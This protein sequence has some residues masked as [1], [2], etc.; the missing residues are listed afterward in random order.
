MPGMFGKKVGKERPQL[1]GYK[2][3]CM[4]IYVDE[5][6]KSCAE[7]EHYT[8]NHTGNYGRGWCCIAGMPFYNTREEREIMRG[9]HKS[10]INDW[11]CPLQS[12]AEH[13]AE[14]SG[15]AIVPPKGFDIGQ[16][17]YM[18][19]TETNCLKRRC[20]Y[21]IIS[22]DKS[23]IG[24]RAHLSLITNESGIE[25]LYCASFDMFGKSI[26]QNPGLAAQK[27]QELEKESEDETV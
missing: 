24:C 18:I 22:F 9:Q 4:K 14:I 17:V 13:D 15:N 21:R 16:I 7:C 2:G 19:P 12:L 20:A 25:K 23:D 27:M 11:D 3:G 8:E 5:L 10:S 1:S 26:F 6:P